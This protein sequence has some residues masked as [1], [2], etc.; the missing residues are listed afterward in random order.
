MTDVSAVFL[1]SPLSSLFRL[2]V[3]LSVTCPS[4]PPSLAPCQQ[5][6]SSRPCS[7]PRAQSCRSRD[8]PWNNSGSITITT[9]PS[10]RTSITGTDAVCVHC[11]LTQSM[12]I[13]C[14]CKVATSW[15]FFQ[16]LTGGMVQWE[17]PLL[18]A[19]T[20]PSTPL[21]GHCYTKFIV[22]A[23]SVVTSPLI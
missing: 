18:P 7:R 1:A 19:N 10:P 21:K 22:K 3:L 13:E 4:R 2:Q 8:W 5:P 15:W 20:H 23:I 17:H 11:W 16:F 14:F 12:Q 6:I 9:T